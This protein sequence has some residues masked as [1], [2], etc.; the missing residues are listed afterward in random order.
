MLEAGWLAR[1]ACQ[2]SRRKTPLLAWRRLVLWC[3]RVRVQDSAGMQA[4]ED[5][6]EE[7]ANLMFVS[8]DWRLS[9]LSGWLLP[10]GAHDSVERFAEAD[11]GQGLHARRTEKHV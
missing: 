10:A 2:R 1:Q 6:G 9:G 8:T 7:S 11:E 4:R 3:A 5:A